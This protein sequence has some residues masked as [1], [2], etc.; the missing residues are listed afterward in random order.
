MTGHRRARRGD[1]AA[2]REFYD[3]EQAA[4]TA[5]RPYAVLRTFPQL[6]AAG[7]RQPEPVLP[8]APAGRPRCRPDRR[9]RRARP[10][11]QDNLH[12]AE[13]EIASLPE[14]R[15]HGIGRRLHDEA[16]APSPAPTAAYDVPRRGGAAGARRSR[17]RAGCSRPRSASRVVTPQRPPGARP[18]R[19]P[20]C[21]DV[22]PDAAAG[23]DDRDLGRPTPDDLV[24]RL[25]RDAHPDGHD[26]PERR[27]STTTPV[28]ID[29]GRH[30]RGRGAHHAGL[31]D[32]VAAARRTSDGVLRRLLPGP[33]PARPP[34]TSS[35]TTPW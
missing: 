6:R 4:G 12:L 18:A 2:L 33:P 26:L 19:P 22:L 29:V 23:Y 15:R 7:S 14:A 25:C 31:P 16:A 9:R 34:T 20:G 27:A 3:V 8:P 35:R 30:P 32:V 21:W 10:P 17:R 28:V 1:D 13:L 5:D 11:L 24:E